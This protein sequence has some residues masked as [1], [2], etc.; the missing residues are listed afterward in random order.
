MSSS[1]FLT[2]R[3]L[4]PGWLT[5]RTLTLGTP[6]CEKHS[7]SLLFMA[8][9]KHS[10]CPKYYRKIIGIFSLRGTLPVFYCLL[11]RLFQG[12]HCG[13][14]FRS[15][16][17]SF[18]HLFTLL[19]PFFWYPRYSVSPASWLRRLGLR[20]RKWKRQFTLGHFGSR[21]WDTEKGQPQLQAASFLWQQ[22]ANR[23]WI[24]FQ[25]QRENRHH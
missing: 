25:N 12:G 15:P 11:E 19:F 7:N 14:C 13:F 3:N 16:V 24:N 8:L 5:S 10:C 4:H 23:A 1:P 21:F 2:W 22:R 17:L 20:M 6:A 18:L 9:G